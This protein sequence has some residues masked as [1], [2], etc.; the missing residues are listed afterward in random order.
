MGFA[1]LQSLGREGKGSKIKIFLVVVSVDGE[2]AYLMHRQSNV[3]VFFK[4][5]EAKAHIKLVSDASPRIRY[6]LLEVKA[7]EIPFALPVEP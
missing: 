2:W 3:C 7:K 6:R 5:A 1:N 4:A